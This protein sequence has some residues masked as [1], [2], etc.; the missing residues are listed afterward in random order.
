MAL[1]V[2][3]LLLEELGYDEGEVVADEAGPVH[4]E[5]PTDDAGRHAEH[6]DRV[7]DTEGIGEESGDDA[8]PANPPMKKM[9][10]VVSA[11]P[12]PRRR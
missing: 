4:E 3:L 2:F 12:M 11:V 8:A 1:V 7:A 5:E 9:Y 10:M 6:D